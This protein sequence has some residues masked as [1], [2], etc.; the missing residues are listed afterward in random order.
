MPGP[1]SQQHSATMLHAKRSAAG[2]SGG[3]GEQAL[4]RKGPGWAWQVLGLPTGPGAPLADPTI[5]PATCTTSNKYAASWGL[6]DMAAASTATATPSGGVS[7]QPSGHLAL[8]RQNSAGSLRGSPRHPAAGMDAQQPLSARHWHQQQQQQQMA[9]GAA[10]R[11]TSAS[12]TPTELSRSPRSFT[13]RATPRQGSELGGGAMQHG[14]GADSSGGGVWTAQASARAASEAGSDYAS[15]AETLSTASG[16]SY[17]H[18]GM[19]GSSRRTTGSGAG[20]WQLQ[21]QQLQAGSRGGSGLSAGGQAMPTPPA[22]LQQQAPAPT[23]AQAAVAAAWSPNKQAV[24]AVAQAPA[25]LYA[26]AS[27]EADRKSVV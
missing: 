16:S 19:Q 3:G 24:S 27:P 13:G 4:E 17:S 6:V 23:S 1:L 25:G 8:S 18:G 21:R 10:G 5:D 2:L 11:Y 20:A 15:A 12:A 22:F 9:G 7:R 26:L 14:F